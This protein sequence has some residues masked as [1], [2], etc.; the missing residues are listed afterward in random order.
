MSSKHSSTDI[1]IIGM[2][3]VFPKAPNLQTY[4][5]NIVDKKNAISDPPK[6]RLIDDVYDSNADGTADSNDRIYCKRGGYID[7][8]ADFNPV[9]FGIMPVSVDGAEPEHFMALKVAE[10]ALK[11]AGFGV[12]PFNRQKFEIILGRGTFVNSGYVNLLQHGLIVDQTLGLLKQL[13]PDLSAATLAE[14]KKSLKKSL[15]PFTT[16]TAPGLASSVMTGIIAN[17]MDLQGRTF[18]V[19]AACA[20]ALIALENAAQDLADGRCDAA[21]IGAVQI[22]TPAVIHMLFTQL[23][24]LS[25]HSELK[26]FDKNTDGTMLGEGIGMLVLKRLDDAIRDGHRIYSVV[27]GVGSSSDGKAKGLLAPRVEGE[28]LALNRAYERANVDPRSIGLIEAHGTGLPLGDKVEITSLGQVFGDDGTRTQKTA[29]GSVKSMIG[30]LIPASGAASLIKTSL[31]LYHKTLPATLSCETPN[32]E[33]GIEKTPLYINTET[34]PWIHG[35]TASPRRAGVNAFGFGGINAHAILEELGTSDSTQNHMLDRERECEFVALAAET[36]EQLITLCHQVIKYITRF[37]ETALVDLAAT[38]WQQQADKP[39][40]LGLVATSLTDLKN[41]L[42]TSIKRLSEA[43]RTQI[44]DRKGAFFTEQPQA[45]AGSLAFMFP[46]EG[47]QY[48]E[49]LLDLCRYFPVVRDSFDLLDRA[50]KD[51]ER[52]FVP[53]EFIFPPPLGNYAEAE[54][55][56]FRMDGAVDAV[57]SADRALFRL[58]QSLGIKPDVIVGHSS[59]EIMALEAAGA[60]QI[61]DDDQLVNFI[62]EGNRSIEAL[63]AADNI[64]EGYLLAVGGVGRQ[65]IDDVVAASAN[66]LVLAMENCPNQFVLCGN[67]AVIEEWLPLLAERGALCQPL[68]FSR[69]Y[70]TAMFEPALAPL[71][72]YFDTL[73]IQIPTTPLYSCLSAQQF[74]AD[75]SSVRELAVLQW[76]RPVLFKDTIEKMYQDGVRIFLEIG[77]RSN[78]TGFASDILKN[79]DALVVATNVQRKSGLDQLCF[80]LS[81]LYAHGVQ[82]SLTELYASRDPQLL[83]LALADVDEV[84][85]QPIKRGASKLLLGLPVL[86]LEPEV[87]AAFAEKLGKAPQNGVTQRADIALTAPQHYLSAVQPALPNSIIHQPL[88]T[89]TVAANAE[90]KSKSK[91]ESGREQVL[92]EYLNTMDAFLALQNNTMTAFLTEQPQTYF[93]GAVANKPLLGN[94][95]HLIPG[96]EI[97]SQHQL[98]LAREIFLQH[99]TLGGAISQYDPDLLALPVLPLAMALEMMVEVGA[100]LL[101]TREM[102]QEQHLQL[103]ALRQVKMFKWLTLENRSLALQTIARKTSAN[104]IAI[105]LHLINS[106]AATGSATLAAACEAVFTPQFQAAT[107]MHNQYDNPLGDPQALRLDNNNLYP[108][109]LFHGPAFQSIQAVEQ[110]YSAGSQTRLQLPPTHWLFS[111]MPNPQLMAQPVLLDAV[112]QAVG[113]WIANQFEHN[114]VAFPVAID[115]I[116][117]HAPAAAVG[118]TLQARIHSLVADQAV[119]GMIVNSTAEITDMTGTRLLSIRGM[120]HRRIYMPNLF[121]D[122]RGSRAVRLTS[123]VNSV[124]NQL[125]SG[126]PL[127]CRIADRIPLSFWPTD[128]GIWSKVLAFIVL[129]RRER[130]AWLQADPA[131]PNSLRWLLQLLTIKETYVEL[132]RAYG[133]E[134]CCADIE[135]EFDAQG[136]VLLNCAGIA[137]GQNSVWVGLTQIDGLDVGLIAPGNSPDTDLAAFNNILQ[138]LSRTKGYVTNLMKTIAN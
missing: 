2:G 29:L 4:W 8:Y 66:R 101:S 23:N 135:V 93:N 133:V 107:V 109:A 81:Q 92:H 90:F 58:L 28:V 64:P 35:E 70:H 48:V 80:T 40:K 83:D 75:V 56:M 98:T 103:S 1:A 89:I 116:I 18:T 131:D 39:V 6:D 31:A 71:K 46:G 96:Q 79:T 19:D 74:P 49:M 67:H 118:S 7:D 20:S 32:P 50:F 121:H 138:Q 115:E 127:S 25:R 41:K 76:A 65:D 130:S 55:R 106:D 137:T 9:D 63:G 122:F 17:R 44:K 33:L 113:L 88:S 38:L 60:I 27:K 45:Q 21:L 114:I 129:S 111:D 57:I 104:T 77:P 110:M 128:A 105:E 134:L 91:S 136:R 132:L 108:Q 14:L 15:P 99:H 68:P 5:Q 86:K 34:R 69:A 11:D 78:L 54:E 102:I 24:A 117:F 87:A 30:H 97:V 119:D 124:N 43:D 84:G 82:M 125:P 16:E 26:P 61:A 37:P 126:Q 10:A 53:S 3:C 73:P 112:G 72:A 12:L 62:R 95:V 36:R 22:S 100:E 42:E 13:H 94:I 52:G 47:S 85:N 123:A 59:G 120:Q 51:H